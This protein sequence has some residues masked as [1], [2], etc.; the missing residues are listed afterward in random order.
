VSDKKLG[1]KRCRYDRDRA[2]VN[3]LLRLYLYVFFALRLAW[4]G[5]GY[6]QSCSRWRPDGPNATTGFANRER[7]SFGILITYKRLMQHEVMKPEGFTN[8]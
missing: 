8:R 6:S 1:R 4:L 7:K 5:F 2:I 3:N